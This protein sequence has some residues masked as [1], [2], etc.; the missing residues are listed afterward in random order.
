[1]I[2][3]TVTECTAG[4]FKCHESGICI[5]KIFKCNG[6]RNCNDGSDEKNCRML[7]KLSS[8]NS[9]WNTQY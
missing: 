4:Q 7:I 9:A 6:I 5:E 3:F 1:M 8:Q 2:C